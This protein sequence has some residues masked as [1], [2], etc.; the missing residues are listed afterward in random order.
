ME[1]R[2]T[3]LIPVRMAHGYIQLQTWDARMASCVA[4]G[5]FY[6]IAGALPMRYR[7]MRLMGIVRCSISFS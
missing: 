5:N 4:D 2:V 1:I 3:W 6:G 7:L